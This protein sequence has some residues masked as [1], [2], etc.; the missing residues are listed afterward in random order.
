M[1]HLEVMYGPQRRWFVRYEDDATFL[2]EH[3]T[4]EAAEAEARSHARQFGVNVIHV[5]ELDG[6]QSTIALEPDHDAPHV[7][8]V[9]G[10]PAG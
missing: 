8:D 10:P 4:R 2:S 1:R 6:E 3:D 9:K 7:S 5:Y